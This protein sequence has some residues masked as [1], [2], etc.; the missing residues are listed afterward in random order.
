MLEARDFPL[1]HLASN[2]E[3]AGEV[4]LEQLGSQAVADRLEAAADFVRKRV[5]FLEP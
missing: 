3:L 4:V 1:E 5:T 2:L